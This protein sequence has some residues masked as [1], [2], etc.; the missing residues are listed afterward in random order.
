MSSK[1]KG[2]MGGAVMALGMAF[3]VLLDPAKKA[4]IENLEKEKDNRKA[5]DNAVGDADSNVD[6][7]G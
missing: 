1:A 3:T 7:N 4:S 2:S 6:R 5:N